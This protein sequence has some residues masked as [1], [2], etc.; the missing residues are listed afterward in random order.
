MLQEQRRRMLLVQAQREEERRKENMLQSFEE[1]GKAIEEV[2][3]MRENELQLMK[4]KRALR[5]QMKAENVERVARMNE[6]QR[7]LTLKKIEDTEK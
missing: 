5:R 7:M 6:Y 3:Q 2:R 1:E 4:E